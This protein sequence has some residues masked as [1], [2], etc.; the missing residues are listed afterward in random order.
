MGKK[1][2][3]DSAV[4]CYAIGMYFLGVSAVFAVNLLMTLP[5]YLNL[6]YFIVMFPTGIILLS[7]SKRLD[8]ENGEKLKKEKREARRKKK[9]DK[10]ARKK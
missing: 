6:F 5:W 10:K 8:K 3:L 9:D 4:G 1:R 2:I 7:R